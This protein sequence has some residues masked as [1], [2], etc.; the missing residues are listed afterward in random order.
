MR[1]GSGVTFGAVVAG[2]GWWCGFYLVFGV[3][4]CFGGFPFGFGLALIN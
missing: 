4:S 3:F 1:L 2:A